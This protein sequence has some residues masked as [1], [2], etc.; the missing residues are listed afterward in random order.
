MWRRLEEWSKLIYQWVS[1]ELELGIDVVTGKSDED[2]GGLRL[3]SL[4]SHG[5]LLGAL[6]PITGLAPVAPQSSFVVK[7]ESS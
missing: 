1:A 2:W 5:S 4:L 3:N 7:L 6:G